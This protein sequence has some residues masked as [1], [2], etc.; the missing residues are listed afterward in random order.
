MNATELLAQ[1]AQ[2]K[3]RNLAFFEKYFPNIHKSFKDLALK[4]AQLNI[5]PNTLE[6]NLVE[7]GQAIY[8]VDT[9]NHLLNEA[10]QF[11]DSFAVGSHNLPIR[12]NYEEEFPAGRFARTVIAS[13]LKKVGA[14]WGSAKPYQFTETLPQVVFLGSGIG[15]HIEALLKLR[16]VRHGILVEHNP[17][18]FLA[19]LY[20]TDWDRLLTP[21]IER[22]D[23]S[24]AISVGDTTES[25]E[26]KRVHIAF[27][28]AWN[29]ICFN[30]PFMP[31][32]TVFYV[33][34]G[35]KFYAQVA[36][37]LNDEIEPFINVWGN[38]DDEINQLNHVLY[39]LRSGIKVFN[40]EDMS[41]DQRI[42]LICGNAPSLDM[43][44]P[45]MKE[46]REKLNIISA[47]SATHSLLQ[48]DIYPDFCVTLESDYETYKFL[49]LLPQEKSKKI[50]LIA[51]SQ[52]HPKTFDLFGEG[53][54]Y[55]K[56]ETSYAA[57]FDQFK[58]VE[59]G[60][61]SATNAALAVALDLNLPNMYLCGM[62][63]GFSS[64]KKT[65]SDHSFY[66][67]D[68]NEETFEDF[69]K[70]LE[71]ESYYLEE[72]QFGKIY[73]T[74]FYNTSRVHAQRKILMSLRKDIK[75]LSTGATIEHT[76]WSSIDELEDALG[77]ITL[78]DQQS[79]L[80]RILKSTKQ[81]TPHQIN[82]ALAKLKKSFSEM[83][84][85]ITEIA[86]NIEGTLD[87]IESSIFHI[88]LLTNESNNRI[89]HSEATKMIRGSI[90]FWLMNLYALARSRDEK[91]LEALT[92]T[93]KK[94][95]LFFINNVGRHS[96]DFLNNKAIREAA[97]EQS[98]TEHEVGI[99]GWIKELSEAT[100]DNIEYSVSG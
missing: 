68:K 3:E 76:L 65:H 93:W 91:E 77:E 49:S 4:N 95:F 83:S 9:N 82:Q 45:L 88:A 80:D 42:T 5:D 23:I 67:E 73:T 7:D 48:C 25:P 2:R 46:H 32:Q 94:Y 54:C 70:S 19:S 78:P 61:P 55:I 62:N 69:K 14:T 44:M 87:S 24:F 16:K 66:N 18:R 50:G 85:K 71:A 72:N 75:N 10:Q 29:N 20:I 64:G 92:Q 84:E 38:Y 30:I 86:I 100:G 90:W 8:P 27:A 35:D 98:I 96:Q 37:R 33:H 79:L 74:P 36:Q 34:Q 6:V 22:D 47:G 56:N 31:V 43:V 12:H 58:S 81:P 97:M 13:F 11:S 17:D 89:T 63:F 52:V 1:L 99:E 57:A 40:P 51:A 41:D 39:N 26:K 59:S 28:A 15:K 21:Y 53:M 60:T